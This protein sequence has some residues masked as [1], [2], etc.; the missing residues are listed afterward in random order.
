MQKTEALVRARQN[1]LWL[2]LREPSG[3]HYYPRSPGSHR[4]ASSAA[5]A[6]REP[7]HNLRAV[8][9]RAMIQSQVN[10]SLPVG[11]VLY[12]GSAGATVHEGQWS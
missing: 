11:L 9:N 12:S 6:A 2:D 5:C 4:Y 10:G 8:R 1:D 3:V 7:L